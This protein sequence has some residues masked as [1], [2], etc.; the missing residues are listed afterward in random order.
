MDRRQKTPTFYIETWPLCMW[1]CLLSYPLFPELHLSRRWVLLNDTG[2]IILPHFKISVKKKSLVIQYSIAHVIISSRWKKTK[3]KQLCVPFNYKF[4]HLKTQSNLHSFPKC[5]LFVSFIFIS[6]LCEGKNTALF[7]STLTNFIREASLII[8]VRKRM[9]FLAGLHIGSGFW[10]LHGFSKK[11][12]CKQ[13]ACLEHS[14][15]TGEGNQEAQ[16]EIIRTPTAFWAAS[17]CIMFC[18]QSINLLLHEL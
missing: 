14:F 15:Y 3:N 9:K 16:Y 18:S 10:K 12:I 1:R 2:I 8:C 17:L 4:I 5:L 13:F 6:S 11:E 7:S